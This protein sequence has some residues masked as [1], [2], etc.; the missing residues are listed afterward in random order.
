MD[1]NSSYPIAHLVYVRYIHILDLF[2]YLER[3]YILDWL[4]SAD[5]KTLIRKGGLILGDLY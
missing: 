1:T 5:H 2:G 3:V 4:Y